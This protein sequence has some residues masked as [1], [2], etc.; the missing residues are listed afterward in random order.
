MEQGLNTPE[1]FGPGISKSSIEPSKGILI[2][3]MAFFQRLILEGKPGLGPGY[4]HLLVK[5]SCEN[6]LL[7]G[8]QDL[9]PISAV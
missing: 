1:R 6:G 9:V 2:C 3:V 4:W 5:L 8:G 7:D